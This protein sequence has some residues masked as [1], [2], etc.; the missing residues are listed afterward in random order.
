[1]SD[2]RV[3]DLRRAGR[4]RADHDFA[5]VYTNANLYGCAA[6]SLQLGAIAT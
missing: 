4:D 5:G 2:W 6:F 1:M 3:F